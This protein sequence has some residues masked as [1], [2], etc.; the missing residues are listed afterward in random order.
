MHPEVLYQ[1]M[2]LVLIQTYD[3]YVLHAYR[4]FEKAEL[5]YCY[6]L[7]MESCIY[8]HLGKTVRVGRGFTHIYPYNEEDPSGPGRTHMD[9]RQHMERAS[10]CSSP[11]SQS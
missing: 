5:L 9:T 4:L 3:L 10:L 6:D 11:V 2:V 8:T 7:C 1:G